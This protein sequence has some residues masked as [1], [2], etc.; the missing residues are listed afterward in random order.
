M[1]ALIDEVRTGDTDP[2]CGR[3][4]HDA[5]RRAARP[6][7]RA[8]PPRLPLPQPRAQPGTR[9]QAPAPGT[10][11]CASAPTRCATGWTRWPSSATW[12]SSAR[13]SPATRWPTPCPP[14]ER[15]TPKACCL[16][17]EIRLLTAAAAQRHRERVRVRARRLQRAHP[18]ARRRRPEAFDAL[19]AER[20]APDEDA[21]AAAGGVDG[22]GRVDGL[23]SDGTRGPR[24]MLPK[25]AP[26]PRAGRQAAPTDP[27]Q[28]RGATAGAPRRP[29]SSRC[30]PTSSTT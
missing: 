4:Q 12:A 15:W 19:L 13:C 11:H 27:P 10:C 9:P 2:R 30:A 8:G 1:Q 21:R 26:A 6:A 5:G 7:W 29:A 22:P 17:F 28:R 18:A 14:L 16:G 23:A 3:A 24:P 25:T 20:C